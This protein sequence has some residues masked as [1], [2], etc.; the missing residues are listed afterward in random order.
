MRN[1]LQ[2]LFL[3]LAFLFIQ[4]VW[5]EEEQEEVENLEWNQRVYLATYPRSGNHWVRQLIEEATHIATSS[6]YR[7]LDP[8]HLDHHFPWGGYCIE[9][10]YEGN[11]R[12]P[13]PGESVV[14][15]T[16]FPAFEPNEF[17]NQ[18]CHK[19]IRVIRHPLDSI[20]SYYLYAHGEQPDNQVPKKLIGGYIN[21]WYRFQEYWDQDTSWDPEP[22]IFTLRYEDLLS[23]P[24]TYLRKI[25]K[26]CKYE[27]TEEDIQR[28]IRKFPPQGGT[29]KHIQLFDKESLILIDR[30][31]KD[32]LERYG[33]QIPLACEEISI[34]RKFAVV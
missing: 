8:P 24:A 25:L 22:K 12:Y 7:D 29:L 17:D 2:K 32:L 30:E 28:A 23:D 6:V 4:A 31:L 5:T 3:F 10:G 34:S 11:C 19:I 26:V 27:F 21:S 14:I 13:R 1:Q 15:K 20:A 9:G 16:H 33:Y 18:P